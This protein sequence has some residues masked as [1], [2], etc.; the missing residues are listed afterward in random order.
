MYILTKK[1]LPKE[2]AISYVYIDFDNDFYL[3]NPLPLTPKTKLIWIGFRSFIFISL[4]LFIL[5]ILVFLIVENV[6]IWKSLVI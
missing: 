3:T 1:G 6:F 4:I 2:Q 5:V